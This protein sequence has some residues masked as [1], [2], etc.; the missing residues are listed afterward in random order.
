QP[1][2]LCGKY[3]LHCQRCRGP[4][5]YVPTPDWLPRLLPA[6]PAAAYCDPGHHL[7][8][9]NRLPNTTKVEN[10]GCFVN[11][12]MLAGLALE[13]ILLRECRGSRVLYQVCLVVLREVLRRVVVLAGLGAF[14]VEARAVDPRSTRLV[15]NSYSRPDS[16]GVLF[17]TSLI[18][19]LKA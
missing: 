16:D 19:A 11:L 15:I 12:F 14:S 6:R 1:T 9:S 10:C 4:G 18:S 13:H 2:D 7:K 17:S 5:L 8:E 3:R